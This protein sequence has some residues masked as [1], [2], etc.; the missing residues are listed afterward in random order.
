MSLN[1]ECHPMHICRQ[2]KACAGNLAGV[3][4]SHFYCCRPGS[5][6]VQNLL[7]EA[8]DAFAWME[9]VKER[10]NF[11][12][13]IPMRLPD[14]VAAIESQVQRDKYLAEMLDSMGKEKVRAQG[15]NWELGSA[16]CSAMLCDVYYRYRS[17]WQVW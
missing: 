6:L 4:T 3:L 13:S 1:T 7:G 2:N 14:E 11:L 8:R 17:A 10:S 15:G 9:R 16:Q 12:Q 5:Q